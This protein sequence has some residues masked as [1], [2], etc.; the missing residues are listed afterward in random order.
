MKKIITKIGAYR[1]NNFTRQLAMAKFGK[2]IEELSKK[3]I[4]ELMKK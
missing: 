1:I 3:E 2:Q 4:K